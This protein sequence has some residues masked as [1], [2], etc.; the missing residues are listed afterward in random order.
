MSDALDARYRFACALARRAGERALA[1][2]RARERLV[3][4]LKGAQDWVS[5]ADRDVEALLRTEIA[6]AYP[7]DRF[8]GEETAATFAG[9]LDRCWIVDP[10]DGTHNFLRGLPSWNVAVAYVEGGRAELAVTYE[11]PADALYRARRGQG[12]WCDERGEATPLRV[13]TTT[14]L[15]HAFVALGHHDRAPSQRYLEIR[16]RM[17]E[18]GVAMRNLGSGALQLAYVARGRFDGFIEMELAIWDAIGGLLL[19]EEAGGYVAP[20]APAT[21]TSKAAVLACTPGIAQALNEMVH[22]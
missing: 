6:A 4:E 12:A 19:V 7:D 15:D 13:A 2:W 11:A 22:I 18:R 16:R 5:A 9:A 21:P 10:I 1:H 14:S 17:M 3:A 8:L 20:F